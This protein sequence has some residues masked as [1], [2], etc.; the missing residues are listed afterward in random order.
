MVTKQQKLSLI[1]IIILLFLLGSSCS[2]KPASNNDNNEINDLDTINQVD[3]TNQTDTTNKIIIKPLL[4]ESLEMNWSVDTALVID[5]TDTFDVFHDSIY[6]PVFDSF[7]ITWKG[8]VESVNIWKYIVEILID[9]RSI[10]K[11]DTISG[12]DTIMEYDTLVTKPDGTKDT[13]IKKIVLELL[14]PA[15]TVFPGTYP[16]S[17][18]LNIGAPDK[19][20]YDLGN[21]FSADQVLESSHVMEI[22]VK[23]VQLAPS[24][25][26]IGS[27]IQFD[28]LYFD[29]VSKYG[30]VGKT[31]SVKYLINLVK[32]IGTIDTVNS[33]KYIISIK[34]L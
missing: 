4:P 32:S 33:D 2:K 6:F 8:P 19:Y 11:V 30:Y 29:L 15:G 23:S 9:G 17:T 10:N 1:Y 12:L 24:N 5:Y 3:T 16:T 21:Y 27:R 26:Y 28:G 14:Q 20:P 31:A 13:T 25:L 34:K 18:W 7:V 22:R